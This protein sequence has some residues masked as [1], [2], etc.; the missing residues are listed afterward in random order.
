[1]FFGIDVQVLASATALS[2]MLAARREAPSHVPRGQLGAGGGGVRG[3]GRK[4]AEV[5]L[6]RAGEAARGLVG[7]LLGPTANAA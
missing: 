5:S 6:G 4:A 3:P 2:S 7:P 1:M